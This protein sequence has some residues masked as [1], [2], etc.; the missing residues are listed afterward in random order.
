MIKYDSFAFSLLLL[1]FMF[2]KDVGSFLVV[3]H[4]G[5]EI[6]DI[7]GNDMMYNFTK[8]SSPALYY[9]V[10]GGAFPMVRG[11]PIKRLRLKWK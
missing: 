4:K 1:L 7:N 8:W 9:P 2:S 6:H 10:E 3:S 5:A 11:K